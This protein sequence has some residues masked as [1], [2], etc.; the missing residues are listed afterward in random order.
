LQGANNRQAL[1]V[2]GI[3]NICTARPGGVALLAQA[4]GGDLQV[5]YILAIL[6]YYKHGL[7]DDV[8]NHIRHVYSEITFGS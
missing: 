1:F 7:T 5:S 4:E 2:K 8:F 6:K 3:A